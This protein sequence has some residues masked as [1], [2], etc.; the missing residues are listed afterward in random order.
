MSN[1]EVCTK[2]QKFPE[3]LEYIS[4]NFVTHNPITAHKGT[5]IAM[6]QQ[7]WRQVV[8]SIMSSPTTVHVYT[9]IHL[10][11]EYKTLYTSKQKMS[12]NT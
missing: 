8:M 6:P 11:Q 10:V 12:M 1:S 5:H 7:D 2:S 9:E 3:R 4:G